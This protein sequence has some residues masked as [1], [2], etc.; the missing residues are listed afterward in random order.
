MKINGEDVELVT[1][2][3]SLNV[4]DTVYMKPCDWCHA[5][6][7]RAMLGPMANCTVRVRSGQTLSMMGFSLLPN[8]SCAPRG[9]KFYLY[10]V[11]DGESVY[12][13]IDPKRSAAHR[14]L[15]EID[16]SIL[17]SQALQ[18]ADLKRWR[19]EAERRAG[20][21]ERELERERK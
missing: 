5:D 1:T 7:H 4:G 20:E 3:A 13:V 15:E 21:I 2:F 10:S 11:T 16:Y 12:R 18:A 17:R 14:Q 19:R 9:E 8:P 6:W